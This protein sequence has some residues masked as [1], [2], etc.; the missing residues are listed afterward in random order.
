ML[1]FLPTTRV[2][3]ALGATDLRRS[4]DGLA[5]LTREVLKQDPTCGALF[6]FCNRN[7]NRLRVLY[8]DG[9]GLWVFAKRLEKGTFAWPSSK[10]GLRSREVTGPQLTLLLAGIDL[11]QTLSRPWYGREIPRRER[12]RR[13]A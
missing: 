1:S 2:Y 11:R 9:T 5:S 12:R 8:F 13:R 10:E 4:F 6:V 7:R 3:L